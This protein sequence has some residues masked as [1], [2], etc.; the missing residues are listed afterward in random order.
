MELQLVWQLALEQAQA[1]QQL[2]QTRME[3]VL[4]RVPVMAR[5]QAATVEAPDLAGTPCATL[6]PEPTVEPN[7][8]A[9]H[10]HREVVMRL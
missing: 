8:P 7:Q 1:D 4:E 5:H 6:L 10:Q 2:E 3:R 9:Q